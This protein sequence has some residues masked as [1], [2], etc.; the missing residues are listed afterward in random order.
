MRSEG[1]N[2]LLQFSVALFV[3]GLVALIVLFVTPIVADGQTAPTFVYVLTMCAPVG[4]VIA[5]ISTVITGRASK[6]TDRKRRQA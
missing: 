2:R 3:I 6:S 5:V 1:P 4:F